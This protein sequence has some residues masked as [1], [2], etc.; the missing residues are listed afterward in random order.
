MEKL[1][2]MFNKIALPFNNNR[3]LDNNSKESKIL[4]LLKDEGAFYENGIGIIVPCRNK[5]KKL[6]VSHIDLVG[7]FNR[8]FFENRTF[9]IKDD[10]LV[11]ALDNT[12][13]NSL[14]ILAIK[15]LIKDN[16]LD[17]VEFL[18]TEGEESGL[19]GMSNYLHNYYKEKDS[20]FVINLDVTNDNT[21]TFASVEFDFPSS[22]ICKQI[23]NHNNNVGFTNRRFTDDTSAVLY[24]STK[25]FSF[26]VPTW[27]YCHTYDSYCLISSLEPYYN[28]LLFLIKDL[29]VSKYENDL[30]IL[31]NE[32]IKLL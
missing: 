1:Y 17:E 28:T 9:E 31:N 18:F 32:S 30:N 10:K 13:T 14:L 20:P 3:S 11:G 12:L 19:T 7:N 4:E 27:N 16:I 2:D 24:Y 25:A 26:C 29:D 6:I 15:E 22:N 21:H 8:G 23:F 5:P